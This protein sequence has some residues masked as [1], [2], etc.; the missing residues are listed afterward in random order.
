MSLIY[1]STYREHDLED[2]VGEKVDIRDRI[3]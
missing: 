2:V 1:V 3:F